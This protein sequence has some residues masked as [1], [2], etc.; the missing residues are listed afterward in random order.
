MNLGGFADTMLSVLLGWVRAVVDWVWKLIEAPGNSGLLVWF[1]KN[2]W[3]IALVIIV[4]GLVVDWC[5][6]L[7]RWQP[8]HIW[9]TRLRRV[10][11]FFTGKPP[12]ARQGVQQTTARFAPV[13][14]EASAAAYGQEGAYAQPVY[15]QEPAE[16]YEQEPYG[17]PAV[18]DDYGAQVPLE[19]AGAPYDEPPMRQEPVYE[20]P[21]A[22]Y[23]RPAAPVDLPPQPS[24]PDA[25]LGNYPG[26]RFDPSV[27][28]YQPRPQQPVD[29]LA[30]YD[31]PG[32]PVAQEDAWAEQQVF[33]EEEPAAFADEPYPQDAQTWEE[34]AALAAYPPHAEEAAWPVETVAEADGADAWEA[35][36]VSLPRKSRRRSGVAEEQ[37]LLYGR[38]P[39]AET[40]EEPAPET[41]T[42]RRGRGRAP[43][44][45]AD[46]QS[47]A[48]DMPAWTEGEA[49][50][51]EG[52]RR[53]R[54][55][56]GV[57]QEPD[58]W[59]QEAQAA[60][61]ALEEGDAQN[62]MNWSADDLPQAPQWAEWEQHEPRK[63]RKA[64]AKPTLADRVRK[65][66]QSAAGDPAQPPK[67]G[68]LAKFL[69]ADEEPVQG[70]PPLVD[71]AHAFNAPAYPARPQQNPDFAPDDGGM[72][73]V[74]GVDRR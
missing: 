3:F 29:P 58:V 70:L 4:G 10:R 32:Y 14:A 12:A 27:R 19:D 64:P 1:G 7:I 20:D 15:A 63:T 72:G 16:T 37:R 71:K 9:A 53:R 60:Y 22:A 48:A 30:P 5:I 26:R 55:Q 50:A 18:Y 51:A 36:E 41:P 21:L 40:A 39:Q 62:E 69:D 66:A 52:G 56:R 2:W 61:D 43:E 17:Q 42:R 49:Q 45:E 59:A 54:R 33:Y 35:E 74:D 23:R 38:P 65:L 24:I 28:P 47:G 34:D 25:Q 11:A 67:R 57:P 13:R 46:A 8:Y 6:W 68:K 44:A 73:D 31:A